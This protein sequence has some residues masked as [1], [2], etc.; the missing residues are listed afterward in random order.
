MEVLV[1]LCIS[2][3][4]C[5]IFPWGQENRKF[6]YS[7]ERQLMRPFEPLKNDPCLK[8]GASFSPYQSAS[9]KLLTFSGDTRVGPAAK[10]P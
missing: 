9:E 7:E 1:R 5:I 4:N 3:V 2:P 10:M 8:S 6:F